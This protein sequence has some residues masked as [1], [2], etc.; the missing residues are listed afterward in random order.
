MDG[1]MDITAKVSSLAT[2]VQEL[3]KSSGPEANPGVVSWL[4]EVESLLP[5][6][7]DGAAMKLGPHAASVD[8]L[9]LAARNA[10]QHLLK[11]PWLTSETKS[12]LSGFLERVPAARQVGKYRFSSD[13]MSKCEAD[14]KQV[15][16]PLAGKPGVQALEIG[17]FE[18]RSAIWLLE[19]VLTHP[20]SG[21]VCVD[22]FDS[23]YV[24]LFDENIAASGAAG[25]VTKR[26]G[27]SGAVLRTLPPEPTYDFIYVDG[28]HRAFDVLE[29]AVLSWPLLKPG[30]WMI[31]DDYGMA[32]AQLTGRS[33][34]SRPDIGIDA[35]LSAAFD[36]FELIKKDFQLT[37]RKNLD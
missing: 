7:S 11:A 12:E 20:T 4:K 23:D 1:G 24:K 21:L 19:N 10:V 35:F 2:R 15:L 31:F 16:A 18:G 26:P 27:R 25:R 33:S 17:S 29:D 9:R 36:R 28:S 13:W 30:G 5:R 34:N 3:L 8:N 32:S 14:W 37:I 22:L 6:L